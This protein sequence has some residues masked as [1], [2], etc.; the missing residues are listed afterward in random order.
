MEKIRKLRMGRIISGI[1]LITLGV[2]LLVGE[3]TELSWG[4]HFWPIFLLLGGLLFYSGY[5]SRKG[6]E[7]G[8]EG[9][10]FPGTYLTILG[11][12]FLILNFIGWEYMKYL[13]A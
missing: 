13:W 4:D 8:H 6:V 9:L 7:T 3:L 11:G 10:L 2:F 1:F 12:L 5:F